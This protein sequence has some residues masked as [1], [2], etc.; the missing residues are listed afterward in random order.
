MGVHFAWNLQGEGLACDFDLSI[1]WG[2]SPEISLGLGVLRA[3]PLS[4]RTTFLFILS[5]ALARNCAHRSLALTC[6]GMGGQR[7]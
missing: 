6:L 2:M 3:A 1:L 7:V 5:W 4:A